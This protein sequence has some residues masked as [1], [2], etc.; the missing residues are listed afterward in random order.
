MHKRRLLKL[1]DL[2]QADARKKNG[3]KFDLGLWADI[4][5]PKNPV[6]CGTMACAMGFAALS[7][8]FKRAGLSYRD[9]QFV[10][11][12]RWRGRTIDGSDA[13]R[14]LFG[15]SDAD[16]SYLFSIYSYVGDATHGA[17]GERAVAKRIRRF[18]AENGRAVSV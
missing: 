3:I 1:A 5:D 13:A 9:S 11:D 16:A 12:F 8:A 17:A 10:F 18:V 2:L 15:I 7:S 6:S 14:K 4:S